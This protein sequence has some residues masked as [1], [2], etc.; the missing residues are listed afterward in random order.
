M[1]V[2]E[3]EESLKAGRHMQALIQDIPT[4]E[5]CG[6][7]EPGVAPRSISRHSRASSALKQTERKPFNEKSKFV[8]SSDI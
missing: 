2:E 5:D 1:L 6:A 7:K 8:S 4:N 3:I